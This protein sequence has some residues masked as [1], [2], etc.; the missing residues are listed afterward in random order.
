MQ[1]LDKAFEHYWELAASPDGK[2]WVVCVDGLL[3]FQ[4]GGA[5]RVLFSP[6]MQ[7]ET[8]VTAAAFM[9]DGT[10]ILAVDSKNALQLFDVD[11]HVIWQTPPIPA[12]DSTCHTLLLV[13]S[14]F[15]SEPDSANSRWMMRWVSTNQV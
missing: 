6:A 14:G 13:R 10:H 11:A 4:K 2:N 15:C 9:P 7:R 3:L 12:L 1:R 8:L 5:N